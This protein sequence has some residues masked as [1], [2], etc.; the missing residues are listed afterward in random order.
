MSQ[1]EIYMK[2][3][4]SEAEEA[5]KKGE[6]PIGA[7][8]VKNGEVIAKAH[9]LRETEKNSLLHAEVVA[10]DRACKKLSG[11]RLSGCDIYVTLEPCH[12]CIGAIVE[13]KIDNLYFG[14]YDRKKGAV[15]SI[16]EIPKNKNLCHRLDW[17]GGILE[18]ECSEIIKKFFAELRKTKRE[19]N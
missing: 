12:M 3:A 13:A 16:D 14:A 18:D 6:I 19:N 5:Y 9:N 4:L 1:K 8:I 17:S 11:W 2:M 10:I 15:F 7:V